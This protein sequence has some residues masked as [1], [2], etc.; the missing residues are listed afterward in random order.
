MAITNRII[1]RTIEEKLERLRLR[2]GDPP[3]T[4]Y[5]I[6]AVPSKSVYYVLA[7]IFKTLYPHGGTIGIRAEPYTMNLNGKF[8]CHATVARSIIERG[9]R[10]DDKIWLYGTTGGDVTHSV[11]S[12]EN[13]RLVTDTFKGIW[14]QKG[15]YERQKGDPKTEWNDFLFVE[16]V[17]GLQDEFGI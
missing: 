4:Y 7:R 3:G 13:N 15:G 10:P 5:L 16:T 17:A 2:R 12:D 1:A 6:S 8:S 14:H 9:N 11:L